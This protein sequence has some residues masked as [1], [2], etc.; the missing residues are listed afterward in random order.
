MFAALR[1]DAGQIHADIEFGLVEMC[2][3]IGDVRIEMFE[4]ALE[5][6]P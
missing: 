5:R 1:V 2:R 3:V 4:Y 6:P